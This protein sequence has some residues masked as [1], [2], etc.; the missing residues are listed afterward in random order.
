MS[1]LV[2]NCAIFV[3][4]ENVNIVGKRLSALKKMTYTATTLRLAVDYQGKSIGQS[5]SGKEII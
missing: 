5:D 2:S 4:N 3:E 1:T